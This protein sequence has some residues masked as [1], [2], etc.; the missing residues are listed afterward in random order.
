M[1]KEA[2]CLFG[3]Q[4]WVNNLK[5]YVIYDK[6]TLVYLEFNWSFIKIYFQC[7]HTFPRATKFIPGKPKHIWVWLGMPGHIHWAAALHAILPWWISLYK[8]SKTL[9][10]SFQ[11]S[12]WSKNP[13]I[14]YDKSTFWPVT[15]NFMHYIGKKNAFIIIYFQKWPYHPQSKQIYPWQV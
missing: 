11:R 6:K 5:V 14:L 7:G 1:S 15:W 4:I 8:K 9:I 10:I 3:Q 13:A 2:W 12:W